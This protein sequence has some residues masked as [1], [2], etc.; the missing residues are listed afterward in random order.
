MAPDDA[1]ATFQSSSTVVLEMR[2]AS[3]AVVTPAPAASAVAPPSVGASAAPAAPAS[4]VVH[5]LVP[6]PLEAMPAP[7]AAPAAP[8]AVPATAVASPAASAVSAAAAVPAASAAAAGL[9]QLR[10]SA[11]SWIE[12][13]DARGQTLVSRLVA[14]GETLALDG[15]P[16]L[17]LTIGDAGATQVSFRGRAVDLAPYTMRDKVARLTLK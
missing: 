5:E 2:M 17:K 13:V 8:A 4:G 1:G 14:S 16:P 10:T 6:T 12:V 7:A 9:L 11:D 3:S 15:V